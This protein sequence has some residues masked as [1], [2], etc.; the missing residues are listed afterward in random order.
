MLVKVMRVTFSL[1]PNFQLRVLS[2]LETIFRGVST[3]QQKG[4]D[5]NIPL[6]C[7]AAYLLHSANEKDLS[8]LSQIDTNVCRLLQSVVPSEWNLSSLIFG[9]CYK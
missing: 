6:A 4:S 3:S 2:P 5:S 7:I 1:C 8:T 9:K